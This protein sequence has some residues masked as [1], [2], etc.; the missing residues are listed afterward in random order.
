VHNSLTDRKICRR[1]CTAGIFIVIEKS[2]H[3]AFPLFSRDVIF[4]IRFTRFAAPI[5][6]IV[7]LARRERR[8]GGKGR[9]LSSWNNCFLRVVDGDLRFNIDVVD[10]HFS[11]R[12][13]GSAART[14]NSGDGDGASR[15]W[16]D[17][18]GCGDEGVMNKMDCDGKSHGVVADNLKR[19]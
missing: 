11:R 10:G 9:E 18:E 17:I 15:E 12:I 14:A 19:K 8:E 6:P 4:P 2:C 7:I 5:T 13:R 16:L 1:V 3:K